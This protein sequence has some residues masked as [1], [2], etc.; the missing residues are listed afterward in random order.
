MPRTIRNFE[1]H[2]ITLR[3]VRVV[4]VFDVTPGMRR[5]VVAGPEMGAFVRQGHRQP[6][7]VS[8]GFDDHVKLLLPAADGTPPTLPGQADGRL[9]WEPEQIAATRNYTVRSF[10]PTT[11]EMALD[12]VRHG[13]GLASSWAERCAVGD[14]VWFA[15]PKEC[16]GFP[17]G[18]DWHLVAGDET[19]LPA[20]GRW[21]TE[22]PVGTRGQ[23]FVEIPHANDRQTDLPDRD[24][25]E[26]NWLVRDGQFRDGAAVLPGQLLD[27]AIR[28]AQWW[29]GVVYAFVAGEALALKPIRRH[30]RDE[31]RIPPERLEIVGYWRRTETDTDPSDNPVVRL[32]EMSELLAPMVLRAAVTIGLPGA[33]E[34]GLERVDDLAAATAVLPGPLSRL[35]RALV[36][37]GVAEV[38][39]AG[40]RPTPLGAALDD[41]HL[42]DHLDLHRPAAVTELGLIGL[43]DS[44]RGDDGFARAHG[45]SFAAVRRQRHELEVALQRQ[46][47]EETAWVANNLAALPALS[48]AASVGLSGLGTTSL[49][50][51]IARRGSTVRIVVPAPVV[52]WSVGDLDALCG[53]TPRRDQITV[54]PDTG[55]AALAEA[56]VWVL[57]HALTEL[58]DDRAIE[59]LRAVPAARIVVLDQLLGRGAGGDAEADLT[60]LTTYG[61]GLR[62][63]DEVTALLDRAGFGSVEPVTIGWGRTCLVASR[64]EPQGVR[65]T[66]RA[67]VLA[68]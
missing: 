24:G 28:A 54:V 1:S 21:I 62:T 9:R 2:P 10:D 14:K 52:E 68:R 61:T 30:L 55:D 56:D 13:D 27:E 5:V 18:V 44:L 42:A 7:V 50:N 3:E 45:D 26:V 16:A 53:R 47:A 12:F 29:P 57:A 39:D 58:S 38:T 51:A 37:I 48:G 11:G 41:D 33:W 6:P 35:L 17:E 65:S 15:G 8:E 4:H 25:I 31:R 43:V 49:G 67:E 20:I 60:A 63:A 36:A 22:A 23:V 34:Q 40:F 46:A 64:T 66:S 59:V 19:A 32:H